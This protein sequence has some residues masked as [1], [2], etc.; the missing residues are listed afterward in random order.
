MKRFAFAV[1]LMA[2]SIAGWAVQATAAEHISLNDLKSAMTNGKVTLLDCN[3]TRT[4]ARGHIPG[5]IDLDANKD[6]LAALFPA[7]KDALIVVY[8]GNEDCPKYKRGVEA[9]AKLGYTQIK[10]YA[11]GIRGWTNAGEATES[12]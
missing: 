9:A 1:L 10:H 8:C 5:A 4:F 11:P 6:R 12:V 2:F 7:Q 3:G